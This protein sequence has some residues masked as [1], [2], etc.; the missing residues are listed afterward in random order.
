LAF[1][2]PVDNLV[3]LYDVWITTKFG[4]YRKLRPSELHS[5]DHG[6]LAVPIDELWP[7]SWDVYKYG[8]DSPRVNN[9]IELS[10]HT[11]SGPDHVIPPP[12]GYP[13]KSGSKAVHTS[14]F[15]SPI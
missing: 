6:K 5:N 14:D 12:P 2:T 3:W 10:Y 13:A 4:G 8:R 15:F 9:S 7:K 11:I 1:G